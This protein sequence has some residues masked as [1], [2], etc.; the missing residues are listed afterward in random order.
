MIPNSHQVHVVRN[1]NGVPS[2]CSA[3]QHRCHQHL[4]IDASFD[5]PLHEVVGPVRRPLPTVQ[6]DQVQRHH[7]ITGK[8]ESGLRQRT[9]GYHIES[10][11]L[12]GE[13]FAEVGRILSVG[14]AQSQSA[15]DLGLGAVYRCVATQVGGGPQRGQV[16]RLQQIQHGLP[17]LLL[18]R[19]R[20]HVV[21]IEVHGA[22]NCHDVAAI[23]EEALQDGERLFRVG[24]TKVT[25]WI[26]RKG[27]MSEKYWKKHIAKR[28]YP[29]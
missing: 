12:C 14:E 25:E 7:L 3:G 5:R 21:R 28:K 11:E 17:V 13:Q 15:Q 16:E 18:V 20:S 10:G 19:R 8:V 6:L 29:L 23:L 1:W 27:E 24:H 9:G 26:L 4:E 2:T 22:L